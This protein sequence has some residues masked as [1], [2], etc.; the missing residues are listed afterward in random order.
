MCASGGCGCTVVVLGC[1]VD[2]ALFIIQLISGAYQHL[3]HIRGKGGG[4]PGACAT[5]PSSG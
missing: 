3:V 2:T 5:P 4:A 1:N